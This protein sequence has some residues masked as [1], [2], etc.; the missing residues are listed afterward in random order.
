MIFLFCCYQWRSAGMT[1]LNP[2]DAALSDFSANY[3]PFMVLGLLCWGYSGKLNKFSLFLAAQEEAKGGQERIQDIFFEKLSVYCGTSEMQKCC[4]E[5]K[6]WNF[7]ICSRKRHNF[8]H[9]FM[10]KN[11]ASTWKLTYTS[12]NSL[13]FF[14]FSF[15]L[16]YLVKPLFMQS[17]RK[18]F[19]KKRRKVWP[20]SIKASPPLKCDLS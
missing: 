12:H 19:Q 5:R 9:L 18:G 1:G 15:L 2:P 13:I 8:S 3:S 6:V 20:L 11:S 10:E 17:V 16:F 7:Q 4:Q 14:F